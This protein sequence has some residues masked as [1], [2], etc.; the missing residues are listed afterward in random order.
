MNTPKSES[1]Y[2]AINAIAVNF[3]STVKED[4]GDANFPNSFQVRNLN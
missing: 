4:L 2:K 3:P 1:L